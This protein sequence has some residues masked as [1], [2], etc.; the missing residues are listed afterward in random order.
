MNV[1]QRLR[2][3][4]LQDRVAAMDELAAG[5]DADAQTLDALV[6]CLGDERKQIQR[7]AAEVLTALSARGVAVRAVLLGSLQSSV[8]IQRWGAAYALSLLGTPP[9]QSQAALLECLGVDD[10]DVRW[11]AAAILLRMDDQPGMIAALQGLLR[12]GD[13]AQ[14]KMAAYCLRDLGARLPTVE[15]V[16]LDATNDQQP[17]VRMAA[18]SG[19]TRLGTDR[20]VVSQRLTVML[21]DHDAGVRRAAAAALG[22]LGDRSDAV[23]AALRVAFDSPDASLKRAAARS[24]RLLET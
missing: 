13:A 19:L 20:A 9:P 21:Q 4:T 23:L 15:Q 1:G 14:R 2:S 5:G 10:G 6:E 11:A 3:A 12:G 18:M 7:R 17:G 22:T 8:P 16:L 24:L